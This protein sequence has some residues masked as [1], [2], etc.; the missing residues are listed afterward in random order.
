MRNPLLLKNF[1]A[2][3]DI[4]PFRIVKFSTTDDLVVQAAA[5][6]D[7]LLGVVELGAATG[8]RVDVITHGIA[9]VEYGGTVTR[10]ALLTS[11]TSGRAVAAAPATGVNNRIIGIAGVSGVSGD[12]GSVILYPGSIQGA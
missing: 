8:E 10:G 2:G 7:A 11:D 5:A 1:A 3:A 12:V 9:E 6:T 4:A